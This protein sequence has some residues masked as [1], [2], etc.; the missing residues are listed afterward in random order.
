MTVEEKRHNAK[1]QRAQFIIQ[2]N[3][4]KILEEQ[5]KVKCENV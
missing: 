3:K 4:P 5:I 2:V 1:S